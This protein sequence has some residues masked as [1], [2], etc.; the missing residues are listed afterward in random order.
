MK[1]QI[2]SKEMKIAIL[3]AIMGFV[4]SSKAFLIFVNPLSPIMGLLVFYSITF[5]SYFIVS[6]MGFSVL[7]IPIHNLTQVLGL[8]ILTFAFFIPQVLGSP[9]IQYQTKGNMDG[10]SNIFY[11]SE[12]GVIWDIWYNKVGIKDMEI[13]R[14]LTYVVTPFVMT[15][16]GC[17]LITGKR[18]FI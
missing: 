1:L 15:I 7:N 16:L 17:Y 10:A 12:D 4:L 5:L 2:T 13:A 9:Y 11:Q 14:I 18:L 8:V 6:K 3:V